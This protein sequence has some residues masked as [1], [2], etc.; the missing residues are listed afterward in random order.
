MDEALARLEERAALEPAN[1][2]AQ[3]LLGQAYVEKIQDGVDGP[4]AGE[5]AAKADAAFDQALGADPY[6][7]E[8]RFDKA[9]SLTY[10]PPSSGKQGEAVA[11]FKTLIAQQGPSGSDPK[12]AQPHILLGSTY[13]QMGLTD[14]ALEVWQAGAALF[15]NNAVLAQ[16]VASLQDP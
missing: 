11:H 8:A 12:H 15:P 10:W 5:L 16:H 6:H 13:Q 1:A 4:T 2:E 14:K 9:V 7:W 3:Y